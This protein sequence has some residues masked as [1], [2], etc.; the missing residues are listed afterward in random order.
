MLVFNQLLKTKGRLAVERIEV[1]LREEAGWEGFLR[2]T[3]VW[4][5]FASLRMWI[6]SSEGSVT[7]YT[8]YSRFGVEVDSAWLFPVIFFW[9][10]FEEVLFRFFPLSW[11]VKEKGITGVVSVA[12][13]SSFLFAI[14][15]DFS[16]FAS[17]HFFFGLSLCFVF[18]KAGGITGKKLKPVL[19]CSFLHF[20]WNSFV[21]VKLLV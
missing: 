11:A 14:D 16:F 13:I 4:I 21:A 17:F 7:N 10:T 8:I 18:L 5:F 12:L 1:Y 6:S 15:H 20:L 3:A 19:F 2:W 9:A